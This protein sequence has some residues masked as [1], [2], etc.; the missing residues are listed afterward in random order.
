M[1]EKSS[2]ISG[3]YKL[4]INER[5]EKLRS[6][7]NLDD[8][9]VA[10]LQKES[11][12]ELKSADKMIEN[13]IGV[14]PI[15]LG[16][17]TNFLINGRDYL[18][19]MATEE[20]SVVAAASNAA[21]IARIKGGFTAESDESI[22]IGQIQVTGMKNPNEAEDAILKNKGKIL[23]LANEQDPVLN[24]FGGGAKDIKIRILD[25]FIVVHLLVDCKDA[26]GANAV[27]TMA[28]AV[29]PLIKEVAGGEVILKI[30]SNLAVK[31]LARAKAVFDKDALGGEEVVDRII[32]AY[33]F[34]AADPYR[35]ATHNKGIMN[36]VSAVVLATG[37]DTRAI[38]SGAHGYSA[39]N[40]YA[41][42][43]K[44]KKNS[45]GDLEGVI[46]LPVAVGLI[47]GAT[48]THPTAKINVKI[49]GVKTAKELEE[50]IASVG[51]AQNLAALRALSSEGIQKGHMK[52][53]AKNI[54]RMAG[55]DDDNLEK[56]AQIMSDEG[57]V[58][59]DRAKEI[60]KELKN[61]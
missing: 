43:T 15:P 58:R 8:E 59:V 5:L 27:N 7:A 30:I 31:R 56:V 35:C 4:S 20:P 38:E 42:L 12:L 52:L 49:L 17:A 45:D 3:F 40:G 1:A 28:E 54:A 47:G 41:P 57:S 18:I 9:E 29:S 34:A 10:S 51:L 44:Y 39:I 33:N 32:Q 26:M 36:G 60:I 46:E 55:A 61:N 2:K 11:A 37:N 25:K 19:P 53:H 21:R 14:M 22:M 24:K 16:V 6:F 50:V 48:T 13:V 23:D